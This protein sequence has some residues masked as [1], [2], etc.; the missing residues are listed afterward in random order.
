MNKGLKIGIFVVLGILVLGGVYVWYKRRQYP[1]VRVV[2][3]DK[4]AKT[5][6]FTVDGKEETIQ[7]GMSLAIPSSFLR[8]EYYITPALSNE[9]AGWESVYGLYIKDDS[10]VIVGTADELGN[11]EVKKS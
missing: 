5:I 2:K 8:K 4:S 6:T 7:E 11:L 9:S 3:I 10:D 1:D